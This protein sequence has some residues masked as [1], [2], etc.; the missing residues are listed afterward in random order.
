MLNKSLNLYKHVVFVL[1]KL[2]NN[3]IPNMRGWQGLFWRFM[4]KQIA[5]LGYSFKFG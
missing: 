3:I 4:R 2:T 1:H 5:R